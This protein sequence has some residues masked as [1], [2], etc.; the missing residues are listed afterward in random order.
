MVRIA[1]KDTYATEDV[2]GGVEVR[3]QIF[4][5]QPV[6]EIYDIDPGDVEE[7]ESSGPGLRFHD[8]VEQ[9]TT[10]AD[11]DPEPSDEQPEQV[12]LEEDQAEAEMVD[13]EETV[14]EEEP[15]EP[16]VHSPHRAESIEGSVEA[17]GGKQEEPK[18]AQTP[19][20]GRKSKPA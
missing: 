11:G 1:K 16:R 13:T 18:L 17:P 3:R 4:A 8:A 20:R 12:T 15:G 6:P 5:G 19:H 9:P 14:A 7:Q 10:I 2:G